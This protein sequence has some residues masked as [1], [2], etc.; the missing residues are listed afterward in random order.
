MNRL[1]LRREGLPAR[2]ALPASAPCA[3]QQTSPII[4]KTREGKQRDKLMLVG[5]Q[6]SFQRDMLEAVGTD[7]GDILRRS[8]FPRSHDLPH[9]AVSGSQDQP[10]LYSEV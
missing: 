6:N 10:Q 7:K 3:S 9:S 5:M 8:Q 1:G 2:P 4:N